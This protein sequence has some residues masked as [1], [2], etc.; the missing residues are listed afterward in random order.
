MTG[1]EILFF[2]IIMP[3]IMVT[4]S[5]R[6]FFLYRHD[7]I[8]KDQ[9]PDPYFRSTYRNYIKARNKLFV[10]TLVTVF[11]AHI[12]DVSIFRSLFV[13]NL[14]LL[15]IFLFIHIVDFA[16]IKPSMFIKLIVSFLV[17]ANLSI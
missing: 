13:T 7:L 16:Y 17:L 3:F 1:L 9:K 10:I 4:F 14:A 6:T 15:P 2:Y 12:C 5:L 11:L 8:Y